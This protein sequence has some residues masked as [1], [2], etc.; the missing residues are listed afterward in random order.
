MSEGSDVGDVATTVARP[1][2]YSS[3]FLL[4]WVG[5]RR[6]AGA[7]SVVS[8]GTSPGSTMSALPYLNSF[9]TCSLLAVSLSS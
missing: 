5:A 3:S 9:L 4:Y 1:V 2:R 6:F 8:W 7:E